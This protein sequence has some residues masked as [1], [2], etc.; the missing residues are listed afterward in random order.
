MSRKSFAFI[1]RL[2]K[3][4]VSWIAGKR[5]ETCA[6]AASPVLV[7]NCTGVSYDCRG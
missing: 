4:L 5:N 7:R 2:L 3:A 1:A 6:T